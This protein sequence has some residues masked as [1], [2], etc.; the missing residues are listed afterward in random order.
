MKIKGIIAAFGV[1]SALILTPTSA[2]AVTVYKVSC[3]EFQN[4]S[5][6]AYVFDYHRKNSTT[7]STGFGSYMG[8]YA[9]VVA[10]HQ[11]PDDGWH[12]IRYY[13]VSSQP[14]GG[15]GHPYGGAWELAWTAGL[16][17][18]YYI[19]SVGTQ[20][21]DPRWE[22]LSDIDGSNKCHTKYFRIV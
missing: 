18:S 20:F 4:Y 17:H 5:S 11:P 14:N 21:E 8:G 3:A 10:D 7:V 16:A 2:H 15:S 13:Y 19:L 1:I 22:W 6:D 12:Q 9:Y